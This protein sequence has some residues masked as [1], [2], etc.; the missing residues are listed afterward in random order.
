MEIR[1]VHPANNEKLTHL[2]LFIA[3]IKGII[4][5]YFD[6]WICHAPTKSNKIDDNYNHQLEADAPFS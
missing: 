3:T 4:Y 2:P 6:S 5:T 1:D